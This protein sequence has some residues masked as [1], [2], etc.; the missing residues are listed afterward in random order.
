MNYYKPDFAMAWNMAF[1]VPYIIARILQLGYY[2]EEIICSPEFKTKSCYYFV[3]DTD[4]MTGKRKDP[5]ERNDRFDVSSYTVYV[6]QMIQFASRRK[7]QSKFPNYKLDTIGELVAGVNK[8]DYHDIC[9]SISELS[10][11]DYKTYVFYNIMDTIVQ[12]SIEYKSNDTDYIFAKSLENNTPYSKIHRQTVYLTNRATKEFD[13]FGYVIGNNSNKYNEKPNE[14]FPGAYVADP[15]KIDDYSKLKINGIPVNIYDN[16]VDFDFARLYPSVIQE[17][18]MAPNTQ[19][20]KILIANPIHKLDNRFNRD[21]YNRGGQF[22]EDYQSGCFLE[23]CSRWLALASFDELLDDIAEY[24]ETILYDG[25]I[26]RKN[27]NINPVVYFNI[28]SPVQFLSDDELINPV[29]I[30]HVVTSE[31]KEKLKNDINK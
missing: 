23:F 29:I 24:N 25:F 18:N 9:S 28:I 8:L 26:P 2:P 13:N 3:D 14:K 27:G 16:S 10:Y 21:R 30:D 15:L 5:E 20:G 4:R 12:L 7:G 31:M 1:D 17:N 22:I 11:K 19:I 6:D